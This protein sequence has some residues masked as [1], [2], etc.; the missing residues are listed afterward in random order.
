MSFLNEQDYASHKKAYPRTFNGDFRK[1]KWLISLILLG[2]YL[3]VP[4]IRWDR[5]SDAPSQAVLID[6]EGRRAYFFNIEIWPQEV[7]YLTGILIIAAIALFL[8]TAMAGRVWCGFACWQTVFTDLFVWVESSF[9]GDR[10][11]RIKRD[12]G[13]LTVD[14]ILRKIGTNVVWLI[15]SF[16]TGLQMMLY[17]GNAPD[18]LKEFFAGEA[19]VTVYSFTFIL[20][21]STYLLAG[22]AREDVCVYMCPYARFQGSMLD[23]NSL[24]V[25]Y[26]A[27]R[28]EP[29][30]KTKKGQSFE[31]RGHCV[32]CTMCV[33]ACPTGIDIRNGPQIACIGCGL[34][35][36]ACNVT[37][38][39]MGLPRGLI[40]YDSMNNQDARAKGEPT[41]NRVIRPRTIGYFG[42]IA[43]VGIF[44]LFVLNNRARI[45]INVLH[46]RSPL[47]VV[48]SDGSIRNSYTLKIINMTNQKVEL[49]LEIKGV[50]YSKLH[51]LGQ[52]EE[53]SK[54]K[55]V[56]SAVRVADFRLFVAVSPDKLREKSSA[57]E[58]IITNP[59]TGEK[60]TAKDKFVGP[61][62]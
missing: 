52:E 19:G 53:G 51:I 54:P 29:R 55:L 50:E 24:V 38:D 23:E 44:M 57:V 39:R 25:T 49:P 17:F 9:E 36:D 22:Y 20:M 58:F 12:N 33:Q 59:E 15:L 14:K 4:W 40:S 13:P 7:Y 6:M 31:G 62:K 28:G 3:F 42:L 1:L 35:I 61:G 60:R 27:W 2:I 10:N 8:A 48:M 11:A 46:D 43:V 56:I 18:M 41:K 34:C 30:A 26:E 47:F 32:E 37:M 16:I 21:V 45:G 5:G